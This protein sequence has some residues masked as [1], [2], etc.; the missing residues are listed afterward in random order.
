[1]V[2]GWG[3]G[4]LNFLCSAKDDFQLLIL[5]YL[6]HAVITSQLTTP[7]LFMLLLQYLI[8]IIDANNHVCLVQMMPSGGGIICCASTSAE[9]RAGH[10]LLFFFFFFPF[11]N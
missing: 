4:A 9:A 10:G 1:V 6:P 11:F 8:G 5:L 7:D 3:R 2:G